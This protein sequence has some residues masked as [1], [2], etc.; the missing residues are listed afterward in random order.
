[1]PEFYVLFILLPAQENF[2]AADDRW[3]IDQ[4]ASQVLDLNFTALKFQEHIP[5]GGE[6]SN[7]AI[8]YFAAKVPA[9]SHQCGEPFFVFLKVLAQLDKLLKPCSNLRQQGAGLIPGVMFV[10]M[11]GHWAGEG[12]LNGVKELNQWMS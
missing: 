1:M 5:H 4:T 11:V 8:Y 10:I 2:F 12:E 9:W 7:P 6:G 3:E